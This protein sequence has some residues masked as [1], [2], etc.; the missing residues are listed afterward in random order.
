M[1]QMLSHEIQFLWDKN[2][3]VS[4]CGTRIDARV[5]KIRRANG[6]TACEILGKLSPGSQSLVFGLLGFSQVGL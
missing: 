2:R 5:P 4:P 1:S 6:Q 3:R